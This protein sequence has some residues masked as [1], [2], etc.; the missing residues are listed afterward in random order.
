[1]RRTG[2]PKKN[3]FGI[4]GQMNPLINKIYETGMVEDGLGN[5]LPIIDFSISFESGLL[6]YDHVRSVK[7][8]KTLETG[9]AFG[10]SALFICQALQDNGSGTHIAI[11]PNQVNRFGSAGLLNIERAGLKDRLRFYPLSSAEALP[12]LFLEK[13]RLDFAFVDGKH[14]MDWVLLEFFY[15]D[16]MLDVGGHIAFDDLW[17]PG[18]RKAIS[19]ILKNLPYRLVRRPLKPHLPDWKRGGRLLRRIVQGPFERDWKLKLIPE[20]IAILRKVADDERK[21]DFHRA[22]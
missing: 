17:M 21:W 22:F 19:F 7:A 9:M 2:F 13:E 4:L 12:R 10:M 6:L 1:L 11:D 18:V 15:I 5:T 3:P 20:K 14:Q 8:R 16:K